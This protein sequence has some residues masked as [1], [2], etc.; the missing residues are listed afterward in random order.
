ML[1]KNNTARLINL[2]GFARLIPGVNDVE[3]GAWDKAQEIELVRKM[4]EPMEGE[5]TPWLE[6]VGESEGGDA[7]DGGAKQV[8]TASVSGTSAPGPTPTGGTGTG[9]G[10]TSLT[11]MNVKDAGATISE[12]YDAKLLTRWRQGETRSTVLDAI[13]KQLEKVKLTEAEK[14][15]AQR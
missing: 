9:T 11:G 3:D 7:G 12:T 4:L 13:D 1:I 2:G 5:D 6:V 14:S 15:S 10:S 8:F